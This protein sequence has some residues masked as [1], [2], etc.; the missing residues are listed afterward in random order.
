[1]CDAC[2]TDVSLIPI[3]TLP[4]QATL[5][6]SLP[7]ISLISPLLNAIC[8]M[9]GR[10]TAELKN[11]RLEGQV[12]T[13]D[14]RQCISQCQLGLADLDTQNLGQQP[15]TAADMIF[16]LRVK[17]DIPTVM[18]PE[19]DG[20]RNLCVLRQSFRVADLASY[21]DACVL[22]S[23]LHALEVAEAHS[24]DQVGYKALK[25]M[26]RTII[27]VQTEYYSRD[28]DMATASLR[29]FEGVVERCFPS[30]P[31]DKTSEI[32]PW[33]SRDEYRSRLW[34]GLKTDPALEGLMDLPELYLDYRP[35]IGVMVA[36]EDK[37]IERAAER[38][39]GRSG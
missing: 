15:D 30:M 39:K 32:A 24:D 22:P 13:A 21:L 27:P 35:L 3:E 10:P 33:P 7:P 18:E 36:E 12:P 5:T 2:L 37:E 19:P 38:V 11:S 4:L 34:E 26:Q 8:Q 17:A 29:S 25:A 1:M 20:R 14:L 6:F 16:S 23:H 9:E 31:L 28:V